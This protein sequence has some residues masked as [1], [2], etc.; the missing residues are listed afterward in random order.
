MASKKE[1]PV[2]QGEKTAENGDVEALVSAMRKITGFEDFNK[3]DMEAILNPQKFMAD[4]DCKELERLRRGELD[5]SKWANQAKSKEI[6]EKGFKAWL[7]GYNKSVGKRFTKDNYY[8]TEHMRRPMQ[9]TGDYT[10][11]LTRQS[12]ALIFVEEVLGQM[13]DG[14]WENSMMTCRHSAD[15]YYY[16]IKLDVNPNTNPHIEGFSGV[17][18]YPARVLSRNPDLSERMMLFVRNSGVAPNYSF[19]DLEDDLKIIDDA[20][21][22]QLQGGKSSERI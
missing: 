5:T 18:R 14:W 3:D 4:E 17:D 7:K 9:G 8:Y 6:S 19:Q 1:R 15:T 16:N 13:S 21:K 2:H 10:I 22:N 11:Y 20:Q 12:Q